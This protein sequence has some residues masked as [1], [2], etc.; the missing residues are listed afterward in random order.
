MEQN[1]VQVSSP[2]DHIAEP[3]AEHVNGLGLAW[4]ERRQ[5]VQP[6]LRWW[7][8]RIVVERHSR[9]IEELRRVWKE[10]PLLDVEQPIGKSNDDPACSLV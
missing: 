6:T 4:P 2:A 8:V 10:L 7:C 3:L 9:L 5:K 1:F